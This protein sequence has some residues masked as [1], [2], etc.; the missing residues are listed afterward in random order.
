MSALGQESVCQMADDAQAIVVPLQKDNNGRM[1]QLGM[2]PQKD[3]QG[4]CRSTQMLNI[5]YK[6]TTF[7]SL[8]KCF[9][10]LTNRV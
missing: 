3:N 7:C 9:T 4:T 1:Q 5:F 8:G 10:Y 6:Y 2:Q